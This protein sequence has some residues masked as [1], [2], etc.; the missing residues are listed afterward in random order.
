MK[1][2]LFSYRTGFILTGIT[3][4]FI[5]GALA[6]TRLVPPPAAP[7]A[8]GALAT[9]KTALAPEALAGF[10]AST[11]KIFAGYAAWPTSVARKAGDTIP[12]V[13]SLIAKNYTN[14]NSG[15]THQVDVNGDG[16]TDLLYHS[17]MPGSYPF[18]FG[19]FL[20]QGNLQYDLAYKCAYLPVGT[21]AHYYGDCADTGSSVN[22]LLA[23]PFNG[24]AAWP[25]STAVKATGLLPEALHSLS[26]VY[27]TTNFSTVAD[28]NGDGLADVLYHDSGYPGGSSK[29]YAIFLNMGN[30]RF[31]M[32]YKCVYNSVSGVP[33][34]YGDCADT[35]SA[36]T[37]QFP[38]TFRTYTAWTHSANIDP[39]DTLM[40]TLFYQSHDGVQSA[41]DRYVSLTDINGDGLVDIVHHYVPTYSPQEY[42]FA[43]FF[44][45]GDLQFELGYK[46]VTRD[47]DGYGSG[48]VWDYFG[49]C[50]G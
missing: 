30:Q 7:S 40:Q 31:E 19:V 12:Q 39:D 27:N 26:R 42:D 5:G 11:I 45:R 36:A 37:N 38:D 17:A 9:L 13:F 32:A 41:G 3:L 33:N 14:S 28:I 22:M 50:A 18:Y 43:V 16:L 49:D 23:D 29:Q 4:V 2:P 15:T 24:Y 21:V 8:S 48:Q 6:G 1:T 47:V 44:N 34:Y 35:G 10:N 20:N 46:C 25:H